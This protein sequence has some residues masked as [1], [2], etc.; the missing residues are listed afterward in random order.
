MDGVGPAD[1]PAHPVPRTSL[2]NILDID[3][4]HDVVAYDVSAG[5]LLPLFFP[6]PALPISTGLA[7]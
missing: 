6:S 7:L 1:P 4:A 5:A 2:A 3:L